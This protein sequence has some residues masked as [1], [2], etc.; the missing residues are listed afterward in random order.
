M[1]TIQVTVIAQP[2]AAINVMSKDDLEVPLE[3]LTSPPPKGRGF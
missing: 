2:I 1:M 3:T